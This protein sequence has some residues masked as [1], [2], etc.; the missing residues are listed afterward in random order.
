MNVQEYIESG[1]LESYALG[2]LSA[3]EAQEVERYAKEYPAIRQALRDHERSLEQFSQAYAVNPPPHL[4]SQVL[5]AATPDPAAPAPESPTASSSSGKPW[6]IAATILLLLSGGLNFFQYRQQQNAREQLQQK[7][8]RVAELENR[9]Q[10][11][12]ARYEENQERLNL[13]TD[14]GTQQYILHPVP[15]RPES[16]RADVY[17][18]QQTKK[19]YLAIRNLPPAPQG[20]DYQLWALHDGQPT[21]MGVI[22]PGPESSNLV[23]AGT[24]NAADAFAVTLEPQGGS[25]KPSL[26]QLYLMGKPTPS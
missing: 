8:L 17:W 19:A 3:E 10:T 7:E 26:E 15:Q 14:S 24:V 21:D 4:R 1:Q 12:V 2:L 25:P 6:A 11:I 13:I 9:N 16:L 22:S 18:N 23:P 5:Q 20:K